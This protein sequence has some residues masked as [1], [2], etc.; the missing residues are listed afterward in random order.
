MKTRLLISGLIITI[1]GGLVFNA[2]NLNRMEEK[3]EWSATLSAPSEYPIKVL[4]GYIMSDTY[5]QGLNWSVIN[6]GWGNGSGTIAS[7]GK[8]NLPDSLLLLWLSVAE[9]KFYRGE[10]ELPREKILHYM[11]E[12]F[13]ATHYDSQRK[14]TY[15]TFVVGLAPEGRVVVWLSDGGRRQ[16]EIARFRAGEETG[17]NPEFV[18]KDD[19][20][21]FKPDYIPSVMR[22]EKIMKPEIKERIASHGYPPPEIYD[23]YAK[24]YPWTPEVR[25]PA[26]AKVTWYLMRMCNGENEFSLT[27]TMTFRETR[28]I[29]FLSLIR[30]ENPEGETYRTWIVFSK[31]SLYLKKYSRDG[32]NYLPL[33]FAE[34]EIRRVFQQSIKEDIPSK[35]V[36]DIYSSQYGVKIFLEQEEQVFPINEFMDKI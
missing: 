16:V 29:P 36:L 34:S 30:W 7:S 27:D 9:K 13:M 6:Q 21:I 28:G 26:G 19:L 10:F 32:T 12:G 17:I 22:N 11:N 14:E 31:D 33:D 5:S 23:S 8:K 1:F 3:F 20:Y 25:L 2:C 15:N 35:L 18:P 4:S 24:R